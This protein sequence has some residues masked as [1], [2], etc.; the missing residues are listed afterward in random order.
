MW[1]DTVRIARDF[2]T[3]S[4][5]FPPGTENVRDLPWRWF[6]AIRLAM[7][8]ISFDELPEEERPPRKIW[9][10]TEALESHFSALKAKREREAKGDKTLEGEPVQNKAARDLISG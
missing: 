6:E 10:D 4:E 7:F 2:G 1:I 9:L 8:F 3:V 5:L